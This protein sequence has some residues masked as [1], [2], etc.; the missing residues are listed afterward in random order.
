MTYPEEKI[1]AT[2]N[3]PDASVPCLAHD[4]DAHVGKRRTEAT[5][6]VVFLTRNTTPA[7]TV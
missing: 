2:E 6:A 4:D 1:N 3:V 5:V 7:R